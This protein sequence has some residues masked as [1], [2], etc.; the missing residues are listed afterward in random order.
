MIAFR[1]GRNLEVFVDVACVVSREAVKT[2]GSS[3]GMYV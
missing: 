2:R 1:N 3:F